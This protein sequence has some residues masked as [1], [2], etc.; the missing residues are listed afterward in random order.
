M[1][2]L[3]DLPYDY[4]ALEPTMSAETLH[5]HHD[6]HH[7]TYVEK[8]NELATQAGVDGKAL[9]D[10]VREAHA[11]GARKLFNH[12]AQAWNHALFWQCMTPEAR[13][14]SAA[15]KAALSEA[16][17]SL[18]DLREAFVEEGSNHFG[19]GWIWIVT[20]GEGLQ[21]IATHD[22]DDT[23]IKEG[24]Y[25]LLVC[26]LWEH[27]YYLDHKNDR[28]AFLGQWFDALA[29]W[30]FAEA[31]LAAAEGKGDGFRYPDAFTAEGRSGSEAWNG[32]PA[33]RS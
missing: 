7:R 23:L 17:G 32:V 33:G 21:V 31:Q 18:E 22:A 3:P 25:P 6:K 16:F 19:S 15:L 1:I 9:E 24:L 12:A 10:I 13:R 2:V 14:P 29:N 8:T 27:A 11:K 4:D 26:D 28:K 20:G 30:E 5:L